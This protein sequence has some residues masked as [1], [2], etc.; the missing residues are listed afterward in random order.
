M[1]DVQSASMNLLVPA[2]SLYEAPGQNGTASLLSDLVTRGAGKRSSHELMSD[3]DFYGVQGSESAGWNFLSI[4]AAT[5]AENLLPAFEIYADI[6]QQAHLP[7]VEFDAARTGIKQS[8]LALE[9][10]PSRK[11]FQELRRRTYDDPWGRNPEGSLDQLPAITIESVRQL[12][13]AGFRPSGTIIG[14][15][16]HVDPQIVFEM[17]ERL[18]ADWPDRPAPEVLRHSADR[19]PVQIAHDSAQTHIGIAWDS[20]PY[21]HPDYYTAWA[22]ANILGG[23]SSSRLFT[24][25]RERR[26][27]CYSVS[28][29]LNSLKDEG[30]V[31]FYAGTTTERAQETLDVAWAE[32]LRLADG[33]TEDELARCRAQAKSSLVMQ[34]ES[35][36]ARASSLARDWY[37]LQR[38]QSLDEVRRRV[39][40]VTVDSIVEYARNFPPQ[41]AAIVTVGSKPLI[42]PS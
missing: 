3:L 34:Q 5:T 17:F 8:L 30:R 41:N 29:S 4:S 37:H 15:A 40:A 10:D 22:A 6:L 11:V 2:G 20:V 24:E 31:Y 28:T 18:L 1:T 33:V 13:S 27:L 38:I 12:H 16:G 21:A 36:G 23:G 32:V 39:D 19:S 25:V 26:G 42:L 9:D 14:V 35:T 7:D